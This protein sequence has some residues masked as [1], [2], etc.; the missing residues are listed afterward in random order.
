LGKP[1]RQCKKVRI[2]SLP[3][4]CDEAVHSVLRLLSL[5]PSLQESLHRRH[6]TPSIRPSSWWLS[7]RGTARFPDPL[8]ISSSAF[9]EA[10]SHHRKQYLPHFHTSHTHSSTKP[11][12]SPQQHTCHCHLPRLLT[13]GHAYFSSCLI[14]TKIYPCC[15]R[16]LPGRA[17]LLQQPE[18]RR[19]KNRQTL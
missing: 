16:L 13:I 3:R 11:T 14:V 18:L 10:I 15:R 17:K 4:I 12:P 1:K 8:L 5:S 19:S 9:S 2:T 6:H 7:N